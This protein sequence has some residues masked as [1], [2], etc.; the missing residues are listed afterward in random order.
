MFY[1]LKALELNIISRCKVLVRVET[2]LKRIFD[3]NSH[4]KSIV[5]SSMQCD[6][7]QG[8]VPLSKYLKNSSS[9]SSIL[10]SK[11]RHLKKEK[12]ITLQR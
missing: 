11:S 5:S 2:E 4:P 3:Y 10:I 9:T 8:L 12:Q 6:S 7:A 1:N